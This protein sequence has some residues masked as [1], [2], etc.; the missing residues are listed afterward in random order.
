V[1]LFVSARV[2]IVYHPA[3]TAID[4]T[5]DNNTSRVIDVKGGTSIDFTLPYVHPRDMILWAQVVGNLTIS[6][7]S[8]SITTSDATVAPQINYVVW[9]AADVDCQ[10]SNPF[11]ANSFHYAL[12]SA[13]PQ[14]NIQTSFKTTFAP[15]VEG[16]SELVDNHMVTSETSNYITD[17]LK[18]YQYTGSTPATGF[19]LDYDPDDASLGYFLN[20]A[21]VFCRGG[22]SYKVVRIPGTGDTTY[23]INYVA[24]YQL[25]DDPSIL[26]IALGQAYIS[27]GLTQNQFDF[28]VP[29]LYNLPF[30]LVNERTAQFA[31]VTINITPT[32]NSNFRFFTAVRDDYM[33][34]FLRP[35]PE[36][37]PSPLAPAKPKLAASLSSSMK[38]PVGRKIMQS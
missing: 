23:P 19:P 24:G 29:W 35:P 18:R 17:V 16:C 28:S 3:G 32:D 33:L 9:T 27:S 5:I 14:T 7:L 11:P 12:S 25:N 34:G 10:F 20:S 15:F 6:L 21:F 2:V 22:V 26:P 36:L 31:Q 38:L 37:S 13:R 4:T 30:T 8:T 1:P